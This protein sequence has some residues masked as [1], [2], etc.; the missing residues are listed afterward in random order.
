MKKNTPEVTTSSA[1]LS[2]NECISGRRHRGTSLFWV[3]IGILTTLM[4]VV[5]PVAA[6]DRTYNKPMYR[7]TRLDWCLTWATDCGR[8]AAL[9]FCNRRRYAD[10]GVFRAER[11]GKSEPTR[12]IGSNQVCSSNDSCTSFAYITCTNPIPTERVFA[13]PVWKNHRLDVCL[14][15]ASDCGKPAADAFCRARG[16]SDALHAEQ[17]AETGYSSTRVI[18]SD[19]TCDKPFCRGFQQII[20]R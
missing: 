20:C 12:L 3:V 14:R 4:T 17:D 16:Y 6:Q 15:W 10:V 19:Q 2:T 13:N 1:S 18:S 7:D 5:E 9:A 8:P 11:V